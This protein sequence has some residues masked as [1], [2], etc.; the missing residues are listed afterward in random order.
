MGLDVVGEHQRGLHRDQGICFLG[1]AVAF[2]LDSS[3]AD[4]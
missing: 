1:Q 2:S 3:A 4:E